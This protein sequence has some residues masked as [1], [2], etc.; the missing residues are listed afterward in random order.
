MRI[1]GLVG[2]AVIVSL[3]GCGTDDRVVGSPAAH[4]GLSQSSQCGQMA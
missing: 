4:F 1:R 2:V 3:G